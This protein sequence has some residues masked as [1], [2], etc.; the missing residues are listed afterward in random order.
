M[1]HYPSDSHLYVQFRASNLCASLAS[2]G[3]NVIEVVA[4]RGERILLHRK[5]FNI[6]NGRI[7]VGENLQGVRALAVGVAAGC[8]TCSLA[9][10]IFDAGRKNDTGE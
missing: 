2:S 9:N 3:V 7:D 10:P 4:C 6:P 5:M 8:P 1:R